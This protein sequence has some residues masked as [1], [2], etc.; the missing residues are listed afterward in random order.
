[1]ANAGHK[2]Y[3]C[4]LQLYVTSDFMRRRVVSGGGCGRIALSHG[5]LGNETCPCRGARKDRSA[6][7]VDHVKGSLRAV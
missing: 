4:E 1:V 7:G 5:E 6:P 2:E 3:V